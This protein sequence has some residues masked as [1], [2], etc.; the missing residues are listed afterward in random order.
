MKKNLFLLLASCWLVQISMAQNVGIGVTNPAA[1][2]DIGG[3]VKISDGTQAA[4]KVLT[5]DAAGLASWKTDKRLKV[6]RVVDANT[7]C[8]VVHTPIYTYTFTL[9]DS[10]DYT[11]A[12]KSIRLAQGRKDLALLIDGV[13][14]QNIL[15][16]TATTDWAEA[17]FTYGGTFLAGTHTILVQPT[18]LTTAWG[19]GNSWGNMIV[20][21]YQ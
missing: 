17:V 14:V 21:L 7:G 9:T 20:T 19:C 15:T 18:D 1:K 12:G 16:F 13:V 4:G 8:Q 3:N 6:I 5:S 11:I 10:T 2:L